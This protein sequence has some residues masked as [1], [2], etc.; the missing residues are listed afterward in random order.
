MAEL[1]RFLRA[2]TEYRVEYGPF[3]FSGREDDLKTSVIRNLGGGGLMFRSSEDFSVGRQLVLKIFIK[4]WRLEGDDLVESDE[5]SE[6]PI[7]AIAEVKR[8][9]FDWDE[10]CYHVGVQF[11]G[12]ILG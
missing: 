6:A 12:R 1:R 10:D 4:G 3:P 5:N 11:L 2:S 8:C 9:I 7:I